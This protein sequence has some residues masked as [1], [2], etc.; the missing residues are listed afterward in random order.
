[1]AFDRKPWI[2]H[3][4]GSEEA[5]PRILLWLVR[6]CDASEFRKQL[7]VVLEEAIL[8]DQLERQARWTEAVAVGERA[9]VEAIQEQIRGRQEMTIGKEGTSW[10]LREEY[11]PLFEPENRP[12]ESGEHSISS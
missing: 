9:Y 5:L 3:I 8:N 2:D 7:N 6:S 4:E 1:M 12:I 10:V 11:G